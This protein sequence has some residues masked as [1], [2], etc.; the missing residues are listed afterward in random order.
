MEQGERQTKLREEIKL[1]RNMAA[2]TGDRAVA[3][4]LLRIADEAESTL[5]KLELHQ[6]GVNGGA[7]PEG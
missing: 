1:C 7:L 4:E 3:A 6:H 2:S 5:R